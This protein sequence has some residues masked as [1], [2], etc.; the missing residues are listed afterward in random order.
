[1]IPHN[2]FASFNSGFL[3]Y[4]FTLTCWIQP[5]GWLSGLVLEFPPLF[6]ITVLGF[7]F[8]PPL[9]IIQPWVFSS[10]HPWLLFSPRFSLFPSLGYLLHSSFFISITDLA[11]AS[12]CL[13]FQQFEPQKMLSQ[14]L[15][16]ALTNSK[17]ILQNRKIVL[18][19][20]HD[21]FVEYTYLDTL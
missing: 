16:F 17:F 19:W 13:T 15:K 5:S 7:L 9:A 10:S 3:Y 18:Y 6:F 14:C 11:R 8:F 1:M 2:L 21:Y 20:Q 4:G 12:Q